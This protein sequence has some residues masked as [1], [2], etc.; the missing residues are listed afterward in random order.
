MIY[1]RFSNE[2]HI[3]I[4]SD[5]LRNLNSS[6]LLISDSKDSPYDLL[7]AANVVQVMFLHSHGDKIIK[8][9]ICIKLV[10]R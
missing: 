9:F 6:F 8:R 7:S 3:K 2:A 1:S 10:D 4:P 5:N